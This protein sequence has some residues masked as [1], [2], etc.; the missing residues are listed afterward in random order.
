M[1][2]PIYIRNDEKE[3]LEV[4][5]RYLPLSLPL[6]R[7]LQF[8]DFVGGKTVDSR[9]LASF[10]GTSPG[11]SFV[12]AY[13]DYSRGPETEMWLFSSIENTMRLTSE[14]CEL[15]EKQ[16]V[17]LFRMTGEIEDEFDPP[18]S[19]PGT[20]MLGSVREN[21]L[22][23]LRRNYL[24]ERATVPYRKFIF[25]TNPQQSDIALPS[26]DFTWGSVRQEDLAFVLSRTQI[27]RKELVSELTSCEVLTVGKENIGPIAKCCN[28]YR[29]Q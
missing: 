9:I 10:E 13:L 21:V 12:V 17:A 20:V 23:A 3:L 27:P 4:L 29:E 8:M 11:S 5:D 6:V 18:R 14:E 25:R 16:L 2:P 15:G 24:V 28:V 7:R 19:T 22:E 26:E 1:L